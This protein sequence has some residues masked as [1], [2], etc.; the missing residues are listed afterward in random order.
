[1]HTDTW[2]IPSETYQAR[3]NG[4]CVCG[5]VRWSYDAPFLFMAHCHCSVCRKHHGTLFDTT[6][7]GP[8]ST[9]HW[10]GGTEKIA[11]WRSS[12]QLERSFCAVCGSKVASV[13]HAAQLVFMPAGA[14]EG[15]L[16]MRPQMH[17]FVGSKAPWHVVSANLPHH[18]AFPPEWGTEVFVTPPRPTRAGV[19]SGSC[20]CGKMRFELSGRPLAMRHCHCSRC[21]QARGSAHATNIAYRLDALRF[22]QGE[23]LLV[24]FDLPGAQF[25]GTAFCRA[26]GGAM[27]RRST[28]RGWVVVPEGALDSDP[29]MHATAHQYVA[30]KAPW[31]EIADGV[32]QF[33]E[34]P[35]A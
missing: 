16:G 10:R 27:P 20:A 30:S 2:V 13:G 15:D 24:D 33:A 18:Q 4:R 28:A 17:I 21:R 25:F 1:M 12:P 35:P 6:I 26:C 9:F 3:V 29:E 7:A 22:T 34:A 14:L 8:L 23:E 31:F 19:T 5:A 11:I 32:P